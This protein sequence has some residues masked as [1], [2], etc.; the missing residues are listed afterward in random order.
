MFLHIFSA[1]LK[2]LLRDRALVFWTLLFPIILAVFFNM[3]FSN[4][5]R[6][7]TFQ[8]FPVAVV[9]SAEYRADTNF[10]SVL[11]SV[12]TG[13]NRMFDLTAAADRQAADKLLADGKI[14]GYITV[15]K[16]IGMTV[17]SSGLD[18]TILKA[19][20]DSYRRTASSV[21]AI[22]R[23]DPAAL[24]RGVLNDLGK[25]TDYT[26]AV[27]ISS[28]SPDDT[29]SYFYSLI[30]MACLYGGFWGLK[31]V[32]DI[33]ANLSPRAARVNVA[34]VHKLKTFLSGF[35]AAVLL[36][37]AEILILLAFLIFGLQISFGPRT[38]YVI[39]TAFSGCVM[40]LAFGALVGAL[41]RGGEG[42]KVAVLMSVSMLG[43][44]LSG[45]MYQNIK[46]IVQ[47]NAPVLSYLN[48]VNLLT[49]AFY[50]LYYYDTLARYA[51]NM[52]AILILTVL[53]FGGTYLVIRRQ[54]Y[55]SL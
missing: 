16:E 55:A 28:A 14:K 3:A 9:Q 4:L 30:A 23:A 51:V 48:P 10:K 21:A 53:F 38:G 15:G 33:Q 12:S 11:A 54:K 1:R 19:F 31:E 35:A 32:G 6:E 47:Q 8:P 24:Q 42:I 40:G 2:C 20:L 50:S 39:L 5:N 36:N 49:D 34:P 22:A 26:K 45:M 46:Y 29:L 7:E 43:S 52:G 13:K 37:F 18:E 44:F 27:P 41:V 17:K 25:N